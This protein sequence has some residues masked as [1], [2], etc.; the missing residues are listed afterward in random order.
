MGSR[1]DFLKGVLAGG[2]AATACV[3]SAPAA[4]RETRPRPPEAMG[5]LYDSTLCVGCKVT[6]DCRRPRPLI[7]SFLP[8][9][10]LPCPGP[11]WRSLR[12][13]DAW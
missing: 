8:P 3:A 12:P 13:E 4:A 6:W 10:Q 5:L 2:A 11:C 7:P 1:R 9:P